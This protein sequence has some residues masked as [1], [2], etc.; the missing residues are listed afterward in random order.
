MEYKNYAEKLKNNLDLKNMPVAIKLFENE[1]D[2]Q[3]YLQKTSNILHCQAIITAS[4][5]NSFYGTC[6]EIG[7][8][9]A[10][11]ILGLKQTEE[12]LISGKYFDKANVTKNQKSGKNLIDNVPILNKKIEAIGYA[13]LDKTTFEPDV[14]A[15]IGKPKQIYNL[16]RACVYENGERLECSVSGTQSLCGD[17]VV[18][19]FCNDSANIS[20]GC[21]GSHLATEF[22]QT[23]VAFGIAINKL[24]EIINALEIVKLPQ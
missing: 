24:E 3:K 16:I 15:I 22:E 8:P 18:N 1:N 4:K 14:V 2:A 7:C 17:I 11:Q 5:G 10:K 12:E 19:S 9:I 21:V 23:D 20:F 6:D 13:P